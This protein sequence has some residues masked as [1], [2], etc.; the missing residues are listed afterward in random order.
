[1]PTLPARSRAFAEAALYGGVERLALAAGALIMI[2]IVAASALLAARTDLDLSDA[3][4]TQATR[5]LTSAVLETV[6]SAETGQ[7]GYLLTGRPDYRQ[8]Y[9]RATAA[10]PGALS[11][12]DTSLRADVDLPRWRAAIDAKMAELGETV[13][14]QQAG[15]REDALAIVLTNRGRDDMSTIRAIARDI[16]ARQDGAVSAELRRSQA[17][18]RLLVAVDAIALVQLVALVVFVGRSIRRTVLALRQAAQALQQ[19]NLALQDGRDRLEATVA[20]R[21]ADLTSAN[22]EVQRFAY[23]VSHDLRAPLLNII[24]FTSELERATH[25]LNRFV[26]EHLEPAG[27]AV[28]QDVR[29]ASREDL[30]ES[31][32]FIQASTAKM[33]RLITA[34]L[35]LSREGRRVLAPEPLDMAA[36]IGG[37]FDSM[38]HQAQEA[39]ATLRLGETPPVV[40]DR[41]AIEQ[42]FSNLVENALKYRATGRAPLIEVAGSRS[43]GTLRYEVRDNGRGIAERDRERVFELFRR[44]GP[45]DT[46]G[47]GIGLAHVRT[48][49][50]R[51]GGTIECTSTR[52]LGST[53]IVLLPV[54]PARAAVAMDANLGEAGVR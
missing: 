39:G 13:R 20:E 40:S 4:R 53:F 32:R 23:I 49:L 33:D 37:V 24:G 5:A 28:P 9:D 47:E 22:E 21:T 11:R 43:G 44:A 51:L 10:L 54:V 12:L 42:V 36:L 25:C 31:I 34:I 50:R 27:V 6:I 7:R 15:R 52:G 48:L 41:I 14:L 35:R 2:A 38:R 29:E 17:G 45:Q 19:A 18:T 26:G 46:A 1:M 16:A 30:P 8:P 3:A